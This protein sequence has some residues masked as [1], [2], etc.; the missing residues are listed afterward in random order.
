MLR[1]LV[2]AFSIALLTAGPVLAQTASTAA[3]APTGGMPPSPAATK[4]WIGFLIAIV[5]VVGVLVASIMSSKREHR[6]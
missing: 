3:P 1:K 6:D 5:L 2:Y 4:E